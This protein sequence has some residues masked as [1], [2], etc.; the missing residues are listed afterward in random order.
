[1]THEQ[2]TRGLGT[3]GS[4]TYHQD[5]GSSSTGLGRLPLA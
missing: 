3:S 1:M 2:K 5:G 4:N